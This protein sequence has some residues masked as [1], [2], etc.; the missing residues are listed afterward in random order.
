[1]KSFPINTKYQIPALGLGTWKA[2]SGEVYK[3]VREAIKIGYRH[4]DC[5]SRYENEK[6][7]GAAIHDAIMV[8]E[9]NREELWI[10]SKLWNTHHRAE[11]VIIALK[12]TLQDLGLDY[13]DL[14]LIHWPVAQK[15]DVLFPLKKEDLISLKKI[16]LE[17]TWQGMEECVM[18]GFTRNIGVA[19]FSVKKLKK[20]NKTANIKIAMNQVE[21]HPLLQQPSLLEYCAKN[22]IVVTAYSPLGSRD[23]P[24]RMKA[25]DEPD[26]FQISEIESIAKNHKCSPAQVMIAWAIQRGT[27]VIPKSTNPE[28]LAQNLAAA[29]IFLSE[30]EMTSMSSLDQ[31]FRYVKGDFFCLKGSSYTIEGLWDE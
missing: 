26:M 15:R 4:F 8:G 18:T 24:A 5:A 23:R 30:E 16:P 27:V 11:D 14:Y 12:K 31:H 13:L 2:D 10:T 19:N 7:I 17:E 1:M 28:R 6:E 29:D 3:A 25:Q 22:D 21:L 20:V 9:V